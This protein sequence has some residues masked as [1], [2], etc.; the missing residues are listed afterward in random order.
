MRSYVCDDLR[1]PFLTLFNAKSRSRLTA[2]PSSGIKSERVSDSDALVKC[3]SHGRLAHGTNN[4]G[5]SN[6]LSVFTIRENDVY[7]RKAYR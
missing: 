2:R 7:N 6:C 5:A 4:F 1:D 3:T